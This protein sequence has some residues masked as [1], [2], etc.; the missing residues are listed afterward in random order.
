MS[1]YRQ[2]HLPLLFSCVTYIQSSRLCNDS[3]YNDIYMDERK[4]DTNFRLTEQTVFNWLQKTLNRFGTSTFDP[5][6][7]GSWI[8]VIEKCMLKTVK[9]NILREYSRRASSTPLR[10]LL[11]SK[12]LEIYDFLKVMLRHMYMHTN[13]QIQIAQVSNKNFVRFDNYT[14]YLSDNY[15]RVVIMRNLLLMSIFG[16]SMY[17]RESS[18]K[19]LALNLKKNALSFRWEK[20]SGRH[21]LRL[22]DSSRTE[23]HD[24]ADPHGR[25][26]R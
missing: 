19:H 4:H 3:V 16:R 20:S 1:A 17:E 24:A 11:G 14:R 9:K 15:T 7:V 6:L 13:I 12:C 5:K 26:W 10:H 8:L 22:Q 23:D 2:T 25:V 18:L 21:G